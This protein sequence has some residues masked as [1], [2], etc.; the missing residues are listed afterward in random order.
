MGVRVG[1]GRLGKQLRVGLSVA[2]QVN[3]SLGVA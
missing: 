2:F 3:S 1:D